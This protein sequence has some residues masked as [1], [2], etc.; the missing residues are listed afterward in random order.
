MLKAVRDEPLQIDEK[1]STF[2]HCALTVLPSPKSWRHECGTVNGS[3][4]IKG[5]LLSEP[6]PPKPKNSRSRSFWRCCASDD[7]SVRLY[8]WQFRTS[9]KRAGAMKH[10]HR[11]TARFSH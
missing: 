11:S 8:Q 5:N 3:P 6:F 9:T 4:P 7:R 10:F 1:L 2:W